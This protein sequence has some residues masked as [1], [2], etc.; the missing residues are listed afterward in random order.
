MST[1]TFE[2][3]SRLETLMNDQ[4]VRIGALIAGAV[5]I[6]TSVVVVN[7][8]NGPSRSK[9]TKAVAV[10]PDAPLNIP[11][12]RQWPYPHVRHVEATVTVRAPASKVPGKRVL[13]ARR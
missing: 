12:L 5:V 13:T 11:I 6:F 2:M 9:H 4:R 1:H 10:L 7:V 8:S 3:P